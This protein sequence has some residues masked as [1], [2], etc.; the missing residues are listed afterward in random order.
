MEAL[1]WLWPGIFAG[2]AASLMEA[3]SSR[4]AIAG[5]A[6]TSRRTMA[7]DRNIVHPMRG[8]FGKV[9]GSFEVPSQTPATFRDGTGK[10]AASPQSTR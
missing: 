7:S 9:T 5:S 3:A 6:D 4:A 10:I 8:S 1:S 2:A